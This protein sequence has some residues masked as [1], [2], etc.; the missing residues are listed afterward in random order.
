MADFPAIVPN[1]RSFGLG[2]SPQSEYVAPDGVDVRFLFNETKRIGQTL[3]L[4][5][6]A[7]TETQIN[8]ITDH[9]V[10]QEGSLIAFDLP[11]EIWSGYTTVPVSA[12]DYQWRY[13]DT[14]SIETGGFIGRFNV[15]VELVSALK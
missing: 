6:R 13:A 2:N 5:F 10:G 15:T 14:F 7:L 3:T 4:T 8:L 9:Y 1:A 12:S 11:S